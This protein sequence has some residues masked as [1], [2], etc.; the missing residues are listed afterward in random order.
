MVE[1]EGSLEV[2]K[3]RMKGGVLLMN[4]MRD[5]KRTRRRKGGGRVEGLKV[6][7]HLLGVEPLEG[8]EVDLLE[9]RVWEG[10]GGG[11][12][13]ATRKRWGSEESQRT[14]I[15]AST[16]FEELVDLLGS[17]GSLELLP[18][19]EVLLEFG[20]RLASPNEGLGTLAVSATEGRCTKTSQFDRVEEGVRNGRTGDEIGDS[21]RVV[22]E[23][24]G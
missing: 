19:E 15:E 7:E 6:L 18:V 10:G 11:G 16:A 4:A 24:F 8:D 14:A 1:K 3:F 13:S 2:H 5:A 22:R 9:Q 17:D 21:S 20:E 23:G 12:R